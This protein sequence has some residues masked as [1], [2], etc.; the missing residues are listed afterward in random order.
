MAY[1]INNSGQI[2]GSYNVG[3][4]QQLHGFLLDGGN[5]TPIDVPFA[6]SSSTKAFGINGQGQTVGGYF[7]SSA[8]GGTSHGFL[9]NSEGFVS[10]DF[11]LAAITYANGIN[12][13]GKIV[14]DY[15]DASFSQHG[16]I[17]DGEV[18]SSID[19]PFAASGSVAIGINDSGQIVG[20]YFGGGVHGFLM[21]DKGSFSMIDVPFP[22][23]FNTVVR[24]I[25][26]RGDLVGLYT[27]IQGNHG[28]IAS[29]QTAI[30]EPASLFLT[31]LGLA[32]FIRKFSTHEC[33]ARRNN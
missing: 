20:D 31:G 6:N 25:N 19:V 7:Q 27:D 9:E 8:R 3:A 5:F 24:D 29:P 13:Y 30:P 23:S 15:L 33:G 12:D 16:F 22:G 4:V 14:G 21:N 28:F 18:F 32:L 10:I 17:Y 2:A 1:G 26:N 11:P